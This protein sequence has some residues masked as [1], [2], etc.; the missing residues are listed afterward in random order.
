MSVSRQNCAISKLIVSK[1]FLR[2]YYNWKILITWELFVYGKLT[3][4]LS[5]EFIYSIESKKK[6]KKQKIYTCVYSKYNKQYFSDLTGLSL[7]DCVYVS[8][9]EIP[10]YTILI[11][12]LSRGTHIYYDDL[13]INLTYRDYGIITVSV[14]LWLNYQKN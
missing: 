11:N 3:N 12:I 8:I 6:R 7:C 9:P 14:S 13:S 10:R 2:M 1:S 4:L 5:V